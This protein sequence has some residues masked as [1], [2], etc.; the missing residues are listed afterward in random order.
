MKPD[1]SRVTLLTE[2]EIN[3]RFEN[4]QKDIS[5]NLLKVLQKIDSL[6]DQLNQS[7]HSAKNDPKLYSYSEVM[8]ILRLKDR[9]SLYRKIKRREISPVNIGQ[10]VY[11]T[12]EEV[13]RIIQGNQTNN[14]SVRK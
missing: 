11:F 12:Q 7:R 10:R 8:K 6:S 14:E 1:E 3:R 4:L 9:S 2:A 13:N 5:G